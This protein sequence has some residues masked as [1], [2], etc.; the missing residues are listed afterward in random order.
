MKHELTDLEARVIGCLIEKQV[1]T[2]DQYP[3]SLNAL[4]AACNQKSNRDPVLALSEA[5][6]QG[7]VDGLV[8]KSMVME[9]SG[10][11]SRVPKYQQ[12]LCNL[13]FSELQFNPHEL[14]IMCELL[15]RGPQTPGELRSR[16]ARMA[17]IVDASEVEAALQALAARQPHPLVVQLPR[18]AGRRDARWAQLLGG[19]AFGDAAPGADASAVDATQDPRPT[20]ES[21]QQQVRWLVDRAEISELLHSFAR[22]LDTRDFAAYAANYAEDGHIE[23]PTFSMSRAEMLD[24]VPK[25]LARYSATHHMSCN[26]QIT[27][28]GD[29]A[30]SRSY[31]Q[32]VHVGA[33]PTEHWDAGGWYDCLYR[34]TVDGWKFVHVKLTAVWR[35]G[36]ATTLPTAGNDGH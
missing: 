36:D 16:A 2:P 30:A 10:F 1:T 33:T 26:H 12:R 27:V 32:A 28:T 6:V 7:L 20:I 24:K 8:R 11:G 25:S 34:R 35:N 14:A 15:V 4:T 19:P 31:L 9:K 5:Q 23:L 3:L 22:A 29:T 18:E 13:E 17:P 21:L